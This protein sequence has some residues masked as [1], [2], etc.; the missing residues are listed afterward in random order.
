MNDPDQ[1]LPAI[2]SGDASAFGRWMG[3]AEPRLRASLRRFATHVDTEAVI[4]ETLLR[5]WQVAPRVEVDARGDSL[6]RLGI[7]I[8]RNLCLDQVRRSRDVSFEPPALAELEASVTE[9]LEADPFLRQAIVACQQQLPSKPASALSARLESQGGEHDRDLAARLGMQ[10]NTF[11]Q[12]VGRARKFLLEC[13][14]RQGVDLTMEL[15]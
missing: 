5:L 7:R 10:L 9:P 1:L 3:V 2:A 15:G 4:Q 11:L 14:R 8:A 12:N 13:L 6:L